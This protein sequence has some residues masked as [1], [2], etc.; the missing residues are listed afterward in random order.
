MKKYVLSFCLIFSIFFTVYLTQTNV[1]ASNSYEITSFKA[2]VNVQKNGDAAVTR[3]I[4][5]N[6]K[7]D[8]HGVEFR[9]QLG[10]MGGISDPDVSVIENDKTI[11]LTKNNSKNDNTFYTSTS[12][13]EKYTDV[14]HRVSNK[15]VTFIYRYKIDGLVTNYNDIAEINWTPIGRGWDVLLH[16]VDIQIS[17]PQR[18]INDFHSW[19][20]GTTDYTNNVSSKNGT[21]NIKLDSISH[22]KPLRLVTIFPKSVTPDNTYTVNKNKRDSTIKKEDKLAAIVNKQ[23]QKS[24]VTSYVY[25]AIFMIIIIMLYLFVFIKW[26]KQPES[27]IPEP[28]KSKDL[29]KLPEVSPSMAKILLDQA[30][31]AD[32]QSFVAELLVQQNKGN[33]KITRSE[34]TYEIE[35]IKFIHDDFFQFLFKHI[36][37]GKKVSIKQIN[38][39]PG[40][41]LFYKFVE[42][43]VRVAK[44]R[45]KYLSSANT[46]LIDMLKNFAVITSVLGL[47]LFGLTA[48]YNGKGL[49]TATIIALVAIIFSWSIYIYGKKHISPYT[50]KGNAVVS[51]LLTFKQTLTSINDIEIAKVDD[52]TL[53]QD[54]LPYAVALGISQNVLSQLR[55]VFGDKISLDPNF[56]VLYS[57]ALFGGMSFVNNIPSNGDG[58]GEY[59]GPSGG[60]FTGGD[61]GASGGSGG[62]AF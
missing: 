49:M 61:G 29:F 10:D 5:Y 1:K 4:T 62:G 58:F 18:H 17:L 55:T 52:L 7:G 11:S 53:W 27:H 32:A 13:N 23:R 45:D 50:E 16:D 47:A 44:D 57:V 38:E 41:D 19:V 26:R 3:R 15:K 35:E 12:N 56:S 54:I 30:D 48:W 60:G 22:N 14:Y 43:S 25:L 6:F 28:S 20:H 42:W 51:E 36:G 2:N 21:V 31:R 33:V 9:E 59:S 39:Y 34:D 37:N 40:E 24:I 46:K 8:F